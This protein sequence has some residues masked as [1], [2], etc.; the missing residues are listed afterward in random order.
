MSSEPQEHAVAVITDIHANLPALQAALATIEV[1]GI[2]RVFCGGDLVGYG[3]HPNEVCALIADLEIPTIYG[4]YDYAIAREEEDCGCAYITPH[5]RELGQR[6]VDW[7]LAHTSRESKQFML[8]LPFDLR[9]AVGDVEV[10][11]V[12]GSPRKVNEYLFED[13]P[14]RLYERLAAG[15]TDRV[16]VFGHTHKPWVHEYGG[17]L[18][19]NCGSVGK[20]KDADPRG[21][22]AVL[23]PAVDSVEVSIERVEYDASA[24][25]AEVREAGLPGE[26]ADKLLT[27][28]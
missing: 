23:R 12:H 11:L 19:V 4:N 15:E 1:L 8:G 18:F 27:A 3:P 9:F 21:A 7:T 17:V 16:L 22:F 24:V 25:A 28:I 20:P 5:D 10:H 26:F 6:S 13:K 14:A 2:G